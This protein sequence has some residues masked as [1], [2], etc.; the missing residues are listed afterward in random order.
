MVGPL[1]SSPARPLPDELEEF[2]RESGDQ[3]VILVSFGSIL[4]EIDDQTIATMADVFSNLPQRVI[5]KPNAGMLD[6]NW[7]LI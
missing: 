4:G 7:C 6:R 2:V 3:G 5:W 1:L